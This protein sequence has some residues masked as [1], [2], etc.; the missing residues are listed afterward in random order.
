MTI[1]ESKELIE[2]AKD[3]Y[4]EKFYTLCEDLE[5]KD[6]STLCDK[7]LQIFASELKFEYRYIWKEL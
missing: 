6:I 7:S 4:S 3:N 2:F 1:E 5:V